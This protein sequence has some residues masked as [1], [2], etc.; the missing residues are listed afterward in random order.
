MVLVGLIMLCSIRTVHRASYGSIIRP[1]GAPLDIHATPFETQMLRD[2]TLFVG[3]WGE[4]QL[5]MQAIDKRRPVL[6]VDPPQSGKSSLLFHAVAAGGIL[7]DHDDLPAFYLDMAEFPDIEAVETTIAEAF[8]PPGTPWLQAI[9][10]PATA[11]FLAFDNIDALQFAPHRDAWMAQLANECAAGRLRVIVAA[12][13]LDVVPSAWE[14]VHLGPVGQ[15]FL[16]EYLDVCIPDGPHPDRADQTYIVAHARGHVGTLIVILTLWYRAQ[17]QADLDWRALAAALPP[18]QQV[19]SIGGPR[20]QADVSPGSTTETIGGELL[21]PAHSAPP[22]TKPMAD[23][24]TVGNLGWFLLV[25]V[26]I[27]AFIWMFGGR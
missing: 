19:Q 9:L 20:I 4:L 8:A 10:R 26:L 14:L 5:V 6:V 11:P 22:S 2:A 1:R 13:Q 25:S 21:M 24:I 7:L 12:S 27:G 17:R 18:P 16:R 15:S 23:G 3:R